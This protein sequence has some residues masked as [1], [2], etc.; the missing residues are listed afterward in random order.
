MKKLLLLIALAVSCSPTPQWTA[1]VG[2]SGTRIYIYDHQ[3]NLT[4]T[5]QLEPGGEPLAKADF[6]AD[7]ASLLGFRGRELLRIRRT[8]GTIVDRKE[9]GFTIE[10]AIPLG[11]SR[12]ILVTGTDETRNRGVVQMLSHLPMVERKSLAVCAHPVTAM[13][14]RSTRRVFVVCEADTVTDIDTDLGIVTNSVQLSHT[15]PDSTGFPVCGA[16]DGALSPNETLIYVL[17]SGS[18]ELLYIDRVTLGTLARVPVSPATDLL[19]LNP[20][21]RKAVLAGR[22]RPSLEILDLSRREI[23]QR[24]DIEA[25]PADLAFGT[26]PDILYV[27]TRDPAG[28]GRLLSIDLARSA[29]DATVKTPALPL[30][31]SVWPG[32]WI[33]LIA[34]TGKDLA[35]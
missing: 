22:N 33:P 18:S 25:P 16:A 6:Q 15:P 13:L 8:D 17:C 28:G 32:R 30:S 23:T 14:G 7:G 1:V 35:G 29:I 24:I 21:G 4:D 27:V 9:L 34:W 10:D 19:A 3:L 31:I 26:R 12:T 11:D 5:L 2:E 20:S